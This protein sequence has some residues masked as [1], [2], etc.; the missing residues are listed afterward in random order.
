ME[1]EIYISVQQNT[2]EHLQGRTKYLESKK[3][4][5]KSIEPCKNFNSFVRNAKIKC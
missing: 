1:N 4:G 3:L 5:I 2:D